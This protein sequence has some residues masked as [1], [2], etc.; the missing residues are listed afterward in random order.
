MDWHPISHYF[1][2]EPSVPGIEPTFT[3]TQ[4]MINWL[5]NIHEKGISVTDITVR[6]TNNGHF[7]LKVDNKVNICC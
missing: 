1:L 2:Q 6:Y 7:R 3:L 4:T 5:L